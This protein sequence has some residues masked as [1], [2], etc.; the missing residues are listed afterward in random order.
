MVVV[1]TVYA[2]G[3]DSVAKI[4]LATKVF[5]GGVIFPSKY[6][7]YPSPQAG[8]SFSMY[9]GNVEIELGSLYYRKFDIMPKENYGT[10]MSPIY[11]DYQSLK[12]IQDYLNFYSLVNIKM[13]QIKRHIFSGYVGLSFR[14]NITWSSDTLKDDGSHRI[15]NHIT[16]KAGRSIGISIIGGVRHTYL[17]NKRFNL[18]TGFEFGATFVNEFFVPDGMYSQTE[19]KDYHKPIEPT[20]QLGLSIG[21]QFMLRPKQTSFFFCK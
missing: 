16:T 8:I 15:N 21:L 1:S 9:T 7:S 3:N 4:S 14:K 19:L 11:P 12:F 17:I 13:T 6:M 5:T 20:A 18:V 2:Q 10:D